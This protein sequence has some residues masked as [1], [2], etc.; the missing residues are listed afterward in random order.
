MTTDFIA[1]PAP[2]E[3]ARLAE[4]CAPGQKIL[5]YDNSI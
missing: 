5:G 3:R 4:P 1:L 2:E